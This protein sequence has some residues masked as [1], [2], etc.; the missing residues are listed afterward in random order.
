MPQQKKVGTFGPKPK[1]HSRAQ[2]FVLAFPTLGPRIMIKMP[3][4][5]AAAAAVGFFVCAT[6]LGIIA[7]EPE[8][9]SDH[10]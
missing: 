7:L 5:I 9:T 6:D 3:T 4:T 2:E 8:Q 10:G 1:M